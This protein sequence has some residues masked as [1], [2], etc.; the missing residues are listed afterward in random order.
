[1]LGINLNDVDKRGS[2]PVHWAC[3]SHS[4]VALAYLLAWNPN[5]DT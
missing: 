4:E 2:T 3:Y 5:L 1:M